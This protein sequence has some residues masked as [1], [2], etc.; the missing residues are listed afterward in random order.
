M[1]MYEGPRWRKQG[2]WRNMA[3]TV[4][5][6]SNLERDLETQR[7]ERKLY[8]ITEVEVNNQR[9]T[10]PQAFCLGMIVQYLHEAGPDSSFAQTL[11]RLITGEL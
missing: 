11:V 3:R 5:Q 8:V 7:L 6:R 9:M 2:K 1:V 10:R 4:K